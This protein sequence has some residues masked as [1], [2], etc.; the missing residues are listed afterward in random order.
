MGTLGNIRIE[1]QQVTWDGV[2]L[3]FTDGDVELNHEEPSSD[4]TAHQKGT[5]VLDSIRTGQVLTVGTV[6]KETSI[7]QINKMIQAGG[8]LAVAA[9]EVTTIQTIADV[10]GALDGTY[11]TIN[12]A[13]DAVQYY[14][15]MN[16]DAGGNDPA[17][18]G[19]TGVAIAVTT[20]DSAATIA[21]AIQTA[22]DALGGFG[23]AVST[24]TVTVTNA[25]TGGTTDAADVDSGFTIA[26]TTQGVSAVS[27]Y[28]SSKTFVGQLADAKRLNLH[29]VVLASTD[30]TRDWTFW[31]AYPMLDSIV[32]SG[33]NPE[34][35][36]ISWKIFPDSSRAATSDL[37]VYGEG[38]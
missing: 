1:P 16:V 22:L 37:G 11:F 30:L 15:W 34:L 10:G 27:G 13:L 6:L 20:G 19:L 35:V 9:A 25:V 33:E 7:A 28:G 12:S 4:I 3:G 2:D 24:D 21:S 31:K 18:T 14:V 26:V 23:A 38:L 29:P 36:S 32:Y 5:Q 17:P 8:A